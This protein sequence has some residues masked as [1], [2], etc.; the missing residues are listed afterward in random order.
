MSLDIAD[1]VGPNL[2]QSHGLDNG[3]R[4]SVGARCSKA[5]LVR[6]IVVDCASQDDG[7]HRVMI[8]QRIG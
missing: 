8:T 6:T 2:R 7:M 4:L 5:G 3:S 1:V